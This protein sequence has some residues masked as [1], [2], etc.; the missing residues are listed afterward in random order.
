MVIQIKVF[1]KLFDTKVPQ[2]DKW[3]VILFK[4]PSLLTNLRKCPLDQV[5]NL[6]KIYNMKLNNWVLSWNSIFF[7]YNL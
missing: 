7:N 1:E 5:M 4:M 6:K 3:L 2:K